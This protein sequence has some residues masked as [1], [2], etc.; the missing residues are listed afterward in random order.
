MSSLSSALAL[1][2][3]LGQ[4]SEFTLVEAMHSESSCHLCTEFH[5]VELS[6]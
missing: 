3:I 4:S 5:I 2:G 6:N 1:K